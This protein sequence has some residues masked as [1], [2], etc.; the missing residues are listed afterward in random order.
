MNAVKKVAI[1]GSNG[2]IGRHLNSLLKKENI[3]SAC[4]DFDDRNGACY[5]DLTKS[6]SVSQ[7]NFDVDYIFLI[8]GLTGT[9]SGFDC[10]EDFLHVNELGL[11][12][13]LEAIRKSS[14]RPKIIFPST[15]LVYKGSDRPLREMDE[16]ETRTIYSVNK[17]ACEG[18]L[19]AYWNSFNIPYTIFRICV[20]YGNL[21]DGD[22][23]FGTIGSFVK[24]ALEHQ[25]IKLYGGGVYKRTFTHIK[26]I[27]TLMIKGG[28]HNE[29]S[30]EIYNIGGETCTLAAAANMIAG[31]I[32][33]T[34]CD[35]PWPEKDWKIETGDTFFDDSKLKKLLGSFS[36]ISLN[37]YSNGLV[38]NI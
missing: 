35:V 22:Y 7:I 8:S 19:Y 12:N 23:S 3:F 18:L 6:D 1:I 28:F 5:V 15:R 26:D 32:D 9:Y 31:K 11:L 33:T 38:I 30:G 36:Y 14:F 20:P 24:K 17:L 4:Y 21:Y 10:Y 25:P 13:L 37:E 29:S 27:C 2:Y 34:I 16:K